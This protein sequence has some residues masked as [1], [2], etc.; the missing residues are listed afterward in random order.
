MLKPLKLPTNAW[1]PWNARSELAKLSE[2][3]LDGLKNPSGLSACASSSS[4]LAAE[5]AS[6][7]PAPSPWRGSVSAAPAA[8]STAAATTRVATMFLSRRGN[9]RR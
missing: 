2:P 8:G 1:S 3:G 6:S 7:H 4:A 5:A 9:R